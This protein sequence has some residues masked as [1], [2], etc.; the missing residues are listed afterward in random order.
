MEI[1]YRNWKIASGYAV[2]LEDELPWQW[3][4]KSYSVIHF[5]TVSVAEYEV[6]ELVRNF[7]K[8]SIVGNLGNI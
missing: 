4:K 1:F 2:K 8:V 6:Y 5:R 3:S 7:L